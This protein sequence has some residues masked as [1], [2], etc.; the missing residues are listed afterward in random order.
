[1]TQD[2]QDIYDVMIIGGGPAGLTA[3]LYASRSKLMT[4]ILDKSPTAGALAY[5][6]K[7]ENYP[8]LTSP[9]SGIELLDTMKR[10][11][12]GFGAEYRAMQVIGMNLSGDIKEVFTMDKTY[13]GKTIIIATG[14][15]GRKPS[16]K[17][18]GEFLGKGV[19]YCAICDA[20]FFR[21]KTVCIIGNS[22]EAVKEAGVLAR[23]AETVYLISPAKKLKDE[24]HPGLK[25]PN[26]KL[27]LG[28]TVFSIEG[29]EVVEKIRMHDYDQ[30]EI[31]LKLSGVFVYLH[32]NRPI[33]DFLAGTLETGE[34]GCIPVNCM[35]ETSLPGVFAAGDVTCTEI[36]QVVVAAS[37]GCIAALAAEKYLYKRTRYRTDWAK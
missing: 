10:Q 32:G 18:E 34:D 14:S 5:S 22:E 25:I 27:L 26:I 29:K 2:L 15:M 37:Q 24:D 7:I 17:G 28:Y 36:R 21:N 13:S 9:V 12:I 4:V 6:N 30:K 33:T 3:A 11:A 31:E 8:G 35:M 16:I 1:M 20:A 23:F 19:S